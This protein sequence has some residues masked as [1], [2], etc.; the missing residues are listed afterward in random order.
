MLPP[1]E[2]WGG[3]VSGNGEDELEVIC[4]HFL[5]RDQKVYELLVL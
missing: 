3:S 1:Q 5:E 2:R 4:S